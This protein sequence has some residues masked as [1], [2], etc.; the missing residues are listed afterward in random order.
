MKYSILLIHVTVK[1]VKFTTFLNKEIVYLQLYHNNFK[2][3]LE[4]LLTL[5]NT[6][7][8]HLVKIIF[9]LLNFLYHF[10][11]LRQ[12]CIG[13]STQAAPA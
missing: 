3:H 8:I 4:L 10:N 2:H 7:S 5:N 11:C 9:S 13:Y 6:I 1:F 12:F